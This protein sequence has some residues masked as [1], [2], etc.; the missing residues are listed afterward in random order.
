MRSPQDMLANTTEKMPK[1]ISPRVHAW[2][3][4]AVT[5]YFLALAAFCWR[6]DHKRG[7]ALAIT[8]AGMVAGVSAMT[9]YYADG[10]KPISFPTHGLLDIL[11]AGVAGA[12]P[13]L[14]GFA[15]EPE[16]KYFF[17]QAANEGMVVSMTDWQAGAREERRLNAA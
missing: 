15:G 12:G 16:A 9:D 13:G 8:N 7:A 11:Q 3:D 17:A 14:L 2:L 6:R 1:P 10:T 5:G 4:V